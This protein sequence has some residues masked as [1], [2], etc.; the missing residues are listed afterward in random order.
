M[1]NPGLLYAIASIFFGI[2]SVAVCIIF[3]ISFP[4]AVL[5]ITFGAFA[6]RRYY[7]KSG[8]TAIIL[9]LIGTV[10]TI[11]IFVNIVQ[12]LDVDSLVAGNWNTENNERIEF[13][14][15]GSYIWYFDKDDKSEYT[16]GYYTLSSGVYKNKK[17]YTMGYT[18]T[19]KQ[20]N[21]S[22]NNNKIEKEELVSK[23]LIYTPGEEVLEGTSD[24]YEM[25]NLQT[26]QIVKI[27]K[28]KV[29]LFGIFEM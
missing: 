21:R 14:D 26:G 24:N 13:T 7:R 4:A 19:F 11:I 6:I 8:T 29:K 27:S 12:A 18:V 10:L 20:L 1:K 25:M 28:E 9:G 16:S 5:A 22:S 3:F 15:R 23:W 17:Q 2:I